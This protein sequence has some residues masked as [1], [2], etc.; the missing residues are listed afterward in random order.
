LPLGGEITAMAAGAKTQP[1]HLV[2]M[3]AVTNEKESHLLD[4]VIAAACLAKNR[5]N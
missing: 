5:Y 4:L 1:I 3:V 2:S